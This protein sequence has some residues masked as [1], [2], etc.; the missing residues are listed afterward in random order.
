MLLTDHTVYVQLWKCSSMSTYMRL[1]VV[2]PA[3]KSG[4]LT[5][6]LLAAQ[7]TFTFGLSRTCSPN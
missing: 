2:V 6:V 5:R 3:K 4:A 7:K 1:I